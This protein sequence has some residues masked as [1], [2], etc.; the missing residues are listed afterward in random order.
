MKRIQIILASLLLGSTL[1]LVGISHAEDTLRPEV[2]K[3]M[4]AAQELVKAQKYKEAMTKIRE[5][6]AIPGRTAYENYIIERMRATAAAGAGDTETA[7]K[8]FESI[9]NSGRLAGADQLKMIEALAATYYRAKDYA[10]ASHWIQKYI[11]SGGTNPQMRQL[12]IQSMYLGGD[13]AA[14]SKE[15]V[16]AIA[17][18]EKSGGAPTENMLQLQA[19]CQ[20]KTK[21]TNGYVLT[22]ERLIKHHPKPEYWSDII[23]R[24]QSKPGF[25]DRLLLDIYRLRYAVGNLTESSA[26]VEFAQL[27]LQE[28]FPAEAKK[29]TSEGF[30]KKLLGTGSDAKR[31]GRLR[32]LANRLTSEDRSLLD[33]KGKTSEK[34]VNV[35]VNDGY[36]YVTHGELEKG[37]GLIEKGVGKDGLKRPEDTM[38]HLGLA[39][40]QAGN[41]AKAAQTL[42][43]VSRS[44]SSVGDLAKLW[45]LQAHLE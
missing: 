23:A 36:A 19:N 44:S 42:K 43:V 37:I 30:D 7:A 9:I 28:G 13:Y 20:L 27:A 35:L 16:A 10:Q 25:P 22:L 34:D 15:N 2:A 6:E 41:N 40:L 3:P 45:I 11:K 31:H 21:D 26:Y 8:A 5:A 33:K 12:L 17:E 24:T 29:I 38:L 39:Y 14:A 1:F 4:L 32:D 18:V